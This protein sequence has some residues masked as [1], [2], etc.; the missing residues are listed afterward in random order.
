PV[1]PW[2]QDTYTNGA[3]DKWSDTYV[4]R[5]RS[6]SPTRPLTAQLTGC[7]VRTSSASPTKRFPRPISYVGSP[8][9]LD[10]RVSTH[11]EYSTSHASNTP[12]SSKNMLHVPA[13]EVDILPSL[14]DTTLSKVYGS[15][16]QPKESLTTHSCAMCLT[17]FPPDATIYPDPAFISSSRFLCRPCYETNGGT[18]GTCPT[19]SRPVLT[20]KSEGQFIHA[21]N[22]FWHKRCFNCT[23]CFKYIGDTPMVDLLGRPS[24]ADCFESCL[25]REPSTPKQSTPDS[26]TNIARSKNSRNIGGMG[27]VSPGGR[28]SGEG[29]P[30]MEELEQRLGISGRLVG[31][32]IA[33]DLSRKLAVLSNPSSSLDYS[34]AARKPDSTHKDNHLGQS[35]RSPGSY[36]AIQLRN[37]STGTPTRII[38]AKEIKQ[39]PVEFSSPSPRGT[40][41]SA[42]QSNP[43]SLLSQ[44][45]ICKHSIDDETE[46][47]LR[48]FSPLPPQ[49][50][51]LMSDVSDT[52]TQSSIDPDSPSKINDE[53]LFSTRETYLAGYNSRYTRRDFPD[54]PEDINAEKIASQVSNR[55]PTSTCSPVPPSGLDLPFVSPLTLRPVK[56]PLQGLLDQ[57]P[58]NL[59]TGSCIGCGRSLFGIRGGGKFLTVPGDEERPMTYHVECFRCAIC[60]GTFNE[61]VTPAKITMYKMPAAVPSMSASNSVHSPLTKSTTRTNTFAIRSLSSRL[62]R[63]PLTAPT[64]DITSIPRFGSNTT[65]PGC[66]KPV[67]PMEQ[68]VV[69]GPQTTRWHASCLVCGGK[70]ETPKG[71]AI[72][73]GREEKKTEPGCG[74]KLDSAAK[75]GVDG[76]V[77]CRECSVRVSILLYLA[78]SHL[79]P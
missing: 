23:G 12:S 74:K 75:I 22:Q 72:R 36:S 62:E 52:T 13:P 28:R 70:K 47:D 39:K 67:F 34:S 15:V 50:P 5:T 60:D 7:A 35:T 10:N 14:S 32:P 64:S 25:I 53:D 17:P 56:A 30:A 68:G 31:S 26:T 61:C 18:K 77:W 79:S 43:T 9:K 20:L 54:T 57:S 65:C 38:E 16:L 3:H 37:N 44:P 2:S 19:C 6:L 78:K 73:R 69:P 1:V 21:G 49:T 27:S 41:S 51:D 76:S 71:M 11:I 29:S 45:S 46:F 59:S 4:Q 55:D 33:E 66:S 63:L 8:V 48:G 24:C 40:R 42:V 58:S